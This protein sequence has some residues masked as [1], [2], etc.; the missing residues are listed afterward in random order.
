MAVSLESF[1]LKDPSEW[2]PQEVCEFLATIMP[3][4]PCL[5]YFT[6]T[7]GYVLCSLDKEDLRR[8]AKNDE[9]TNV[10]WTEL[11]A[12]RRGTIQAPKGSS[13]KEEF[14]QRGGIDPRTMI[15]IYV[16]AARQD[17]A[18]ELEV[19][20]T[21]SVWFLKEQISVHEGTPPETQRLVAGGLTMQ[22]DRTL[23]SYGVRHG[24]SVLLIPQLRDQ[25]RQRPTTF[26]PRGPLMVPGSK[27]W[28]PSAS[29]G[30]PFIP[31]LYSD[32]SRNFPVSIEFANANDREAF[33]EAA[34]LSPPWL[35]I[36]PGGPGRGPAEAKA[37]LDP[38][39]GTVRLEATTGS[40][41]VPSSCY[42]AYA[43]FGGRGGQVRVNVVT[44]AVVSAC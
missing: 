26:A 9:A 36:L 1:R 17:C 41:L 11:A 21:D 18:L 7:S 10:I 8:Q 19:S 3:G 4:H 35:E 33:T 16:K 20:P 15:T 6:Y 29:S 12:R 37:R 39:T 13:A 31:V 43:H 38:D 22:D 14:V 2:T 27:A 30:G 28:S 44:G 42:E 34:K 32:V 24:T 5:D 25:V 23:T 40:Q